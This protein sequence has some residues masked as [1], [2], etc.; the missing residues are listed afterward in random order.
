MTEN[1]VA[2]LKCYK[3]NILTIV[4]VLRPLY[5]FFI[6]IWIVWQLNKKIRSN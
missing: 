3:K 2:N 1:D 4:F 6:Y 5:P